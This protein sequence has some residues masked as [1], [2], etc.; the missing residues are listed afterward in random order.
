MSKKCQLILV[1]LILICGIYL[2]HEGYYE[3]E[4]RKKG[5]T[6]KDIPLD[7]LGFGNYVS[8]YIDDYVKKEVLSPAGVEYSGVSQIYTEGN[9][10]YSIYTVPGAENYF[11]QVMVKE[12]GTLNKLE[13]MDDEPV[14]F[15]G[16]VV[17]EPFKI[18]KEW[19]KGLK[20]EIYPY[21][22]NI[23]SDIIIQETDIPPVGYSIYVGIFCVNLAVIGYFWIGGIKSCIPKI[24]LTIGA[25]DKNY[26]SY[27]V[28][29]EYE[30]EKKHLIRLLNEQSQIK[31]TYIIWVFFLGIAIFIFVNMP[32]VF[33]MLGLI[34]LITSFIGLWTCFINSGNII[35]VYFA[36]NND[37]RS[38]YL[39]II[40]CK[41]NIAKLEK[42]IGKLKT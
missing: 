33:K 22:D 30:L 17:N 21:F 26:F 29:N 11:L 34:P 36:K 5:E 16:Y 15:E 2:I 25:T 31:K 35:A 24:D 39:E 19:Y 32:F 1:L 40:E 28:E 14:Y 23:I 27:N 42:A 20:E 38:V 12:T 3:H 4:C 9:D 7:D 37:K 6:L 10:V 13:N 18:N 41:R 8:F